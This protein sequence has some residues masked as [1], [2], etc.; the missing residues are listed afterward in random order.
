MPQREWSRREPCDIDGKA[1]RP[2]ERA[3][4][5]LYHDEYLYLCPS[6]SLSS[7]FVNNLTPDHGHNTACV[8]NFRLGNFHDVA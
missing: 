3:R 6:T 1:F 8:E 4:A 2:S 7:I 5:S